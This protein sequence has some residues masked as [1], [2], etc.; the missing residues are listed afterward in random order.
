MSYTRHPKVTL[1]KLNE[2]PAV[3]LDLGQRFELYIKTSKINYALTLELNVPVRKLT[4]A[5][6]NFASY[7]DKIE[8]N[9]VN[10]PDR[11]GDH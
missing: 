8:N 11:H 1:I 6:H 3:N 10:P 5:L 2:L 9:E 4:Q 7:I